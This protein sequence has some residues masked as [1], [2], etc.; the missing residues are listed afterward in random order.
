MRQ[1]GQCNCCLIVESNCFH[2]FHVEPGE[3]AEDQEDE[4]EEEEQPPPTESQS[5]SANPWTYGNVAKVAHDREEAAPKPSTSS[6]PQWRPTIVPVASSAPK[7]AKAPNKEGWVKVANN[8][9][10][11]QQQQ[12][13]GKKKKNKKKAAK[14]VDPMAEKAQKALELWD[15][16]EEEGEQVLNSEFASNKK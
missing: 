1:V 14:P 10:T 2:C 16:E 11:K 9:Q 12:Q 4:E 7:S 13:P 6:K 5:Q 15:S 8:N 3:F